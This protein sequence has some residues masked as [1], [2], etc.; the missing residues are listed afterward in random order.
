MHQAARLNDRLVQT[1][2]ITMVVNKI[3][4]AVIRGSTIGPRHL[5]VIYTKDAKERLLKGNIIY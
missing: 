4:R 3:K 2:L 1:L 5:D